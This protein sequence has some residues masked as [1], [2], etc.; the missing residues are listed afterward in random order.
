MKNKII[1]SSIL[2]IAMCLS[3]IA[4]STF[5]LF[6]SESEVNVTVTSGKVS[7]LATAGDVTY[8]STY[9][10][11]LGNVTK[12]GN[13]IILENVTPGDFVDFTI[14][15]DN[16]STVA[17]KYRT[18][19]TISGD[20]ELT[21]ALVVSFGGKTSAE[22]T[23]DWATIGTDEGDAT[24]N[25]HISL[26]ED[27]DNDCQG[28]T[29]TITYVVEAVQGN[30][31]EQTTVNTAD[32]FKAAL[33]NAQ[34]GEVINATGVNVSVAEL[35]TSTSGNRN[36]ID[37]TSGVTVKGLTLDFASS[38]D[39]ILIND[40]AEAGEVVF[41]NCTF[42]S[43]DF[44][45]ALYVQNESQVEKTKVVFNNCTFASAKVI[46]ACSYYPKY[47]E[48][49]FNNCSFNLNDEGYGLIQCMGGNTVFNKCAF[50]ISGSS[51]MGSS[52]ITLYGHI[53]L[54]SERTTTNV[55]VNQCT[56]V[57]A[58]HKYSYQGSCNYTVNP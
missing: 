44:T 48:F 26:P 6:T 8:G 14:T 27:A 33:A 42:T 35:A 20:A 13:E 57:P 28:K 11:T 12:N 52:T 51:S 29:C 38:N 9:G 4:G 19:V 5:A 43:P 39:T 46:V 47:G 54:Y 15:V 23:S 2:T 22:A 30:Y 25:V 45:G 24:V 56:G 34:P 7:V 18:V 21:G 17:V 49:E 50:N 41:D 31:V 1:I 32:E 37:L 40:G 53:N 10:S 55:T 36:T 58:V 3:M 16:Q